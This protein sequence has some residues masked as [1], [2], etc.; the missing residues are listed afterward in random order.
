MVD[1]FS[2]FL[3]FF[4]GRYSEINGIYYSS[5][6]IYKYIALYWAILRV[7]KSLL[8]FWYIYIIIMFTFA[9][10]RP[11]LLLSKSLLTL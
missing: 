1:F 4:A 8:T 2:L 9:L 5:Y 6:C 10:Y 7:S 3:K 11:I